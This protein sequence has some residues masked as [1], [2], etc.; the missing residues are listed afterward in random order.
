MRVPNNGRQVSFTISVSPDV[1]EELDSVASLCGLPRSTLI[2]HIIKG[3]LSTLP[4][5][6]GS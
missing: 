1:V 4:Q 6:A 5:R 2:R 3:W